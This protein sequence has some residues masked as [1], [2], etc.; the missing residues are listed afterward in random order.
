MITKNDISNNS[1][2]MAVPY[3]RIFKWI[4][5]VCFIVMGGLYIRERKKNK[6]KEK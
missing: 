5:L 2:K 4:F 1:E 3:N 6:P